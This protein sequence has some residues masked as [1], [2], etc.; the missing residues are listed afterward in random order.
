MAV[1]GDATTDRS[2]GSPSTT[3]RFA[4]WLAGWRVAIRIARRDARRYKW[5]SALIVVMVGLPVLLLTS[6][7]TLMATNDISMAESVPG[8]MGSA[9][10]R[11]YVG[12]DD[13]RLTQ[14][15]D[16]QPIDSNTASGTTTSSTDASSTDST[17]TSEG[18]A[19]LPVPGYAAGSA[20]TT[21]KV[22]SLTGGHVVQTLDAWIRVTLGD[23]RPSMPVLG[24]DARDPLARG[25]TELVS[26]RWASTPSEVVVTAA[27]VANGLP[28][29]GTL[30]TT[31]TDGK[32]RQLAVVG[33]A[34]AL[35]E[36]YQPPFLVA[37]PALTKDVTDEDRVSAAFLV[38]RTDAVTWSDVRRMNDYGLLVK[39]R[40]VFLHPPSATDLGPEVARR[41]SDQS[42]FDIV[43]LLAAV[44]LFIE[45]TLL[46]GPAFAVS[47]ARQR[48]SLALAASNGAEAR[49]LRRYVLG[50]AVVLG[51]LSAAIAVV[52]GV[53][54]TLAGLTWWQA[55]HAD[56]VIGPFEVS[57]PR[58]AGVFIC[59][60][61][62]SMVAALLPAKGI[63]RL[64]IVSVLAGRSGDR[65]VRRGL[66]AAG[67][68]V[69]VVSGIALIWSVVSG[70]EAG[71]G[72]SEYLVVGGAVGL[73][74]GCLMVIPALLALVGR[75]GTRL[76]LPL[77]LAT[78]DTA[79]QRGRST[80]AVAAIMAAVA[81]LTALSI[82]AAS[83][84]RQQQ[85][86]YTPQRPMGTGA[87]IMSGEDSNDRS[88]RTVLDRYAPQLKM[89]PV[90]TLTDRGFASTN[91]PK[92]WWV[93]LA[94][95]GCTEAEIMAIYGGKGDVAGC[96]ALTNDSSSMLQVGGLASLS[97]LPLS[98]PQ[99]AVLESGG[100]LV[101]DP[102]LAPDGKVNAI[103][104][105]AAQ[106]RSGVTT[107]Y[108]ITQRTRLP[109][110]VVDP[111]IWA[112][113]FRGQTVGPAW[114]LPGTATRLG[115]PVRIEKLNLS[116]PTGTITPEVEAA[117]ADRLGD[118]YTMYVERG[119]R[120]PYWVFL[121]IAFGVTGLLV[122]IAS[123]ISTALSLAESQ[124]D[125][126]T[127]SAVGATRHTRRGIAAS[128]A[129]VVAACGCL[130]GV[131]VGM[132]PGIA[133]TWPLT[134][135]IADQVTGRMTTQSPIIVIP[136][137]P[138]VAVCVAVPLLAAGLAWLAVRRH[139]QLTRRL[140]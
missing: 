39:S 17:D 111:R 22:K 27:G 15:A 93:A 74:L 29:R 58:V 76:V 117:V 95:P 49:Q 65:K 54:L 92:V 71:L 96:E 120:N 47:A 44:G 57:W 104:G 50:Q 88:V 1:A 64:D 86:A 59:A 78:R 6:G 109:A 37:L 68:V 60:V 13:H 125:M 3:S 94:P 35:G 42:Q 53:L 7:I 119:F 139:P 2:G 107:G 32:P 115:W 108:A 98:K 81:A 126:A 79:R 40:Q 73:V 14:S 101:T 36:S 118:G 75:L 138:L 20:W 131:A 26:G 24:I 34:T 128:Q 31:G 100:I 9:Q 41:A 28:R 84:T 113:A 43:L 89:E 38:E 51:V 8:L 82:G 69:M 129:W 85:D 132:V 123:L 21:D 70:G 133:V 33:V 112:A 105:T 83:D 116:S 66:P 46:A 80:P 48:R 72:L 10:A 23:R 62:A 102:R 136:W 5:R 90:G 137:L 19:A 25:L 45:T 52:A 127:L 122:L 140:A 63:A 67:V 11:I 61:A 4:R 55:G 56:F 30:T 106:D 91:S 18:A 77:R 124:N 87:I 97:S 134:S 114:I 135:R 103:S 110:V 99:R 12:S 130:L 121:L 16:G